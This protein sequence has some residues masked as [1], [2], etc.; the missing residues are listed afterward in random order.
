MRGAGSPLRRSSAHGFTLIEVLIGTAILGLTMAL[1]GS[2]LFAA[3]KS[4]RTGEARLGDMDSKRSVFA[5]LRRQLGEAFPLTELR[6]DVQHVLFDGGPERV[7]L[8]GHLPAHRGGG[9]LQII[10]LRTESTGAQ[11]GL[12]LY[13]R[14]AWP[15]VAF[16]TSIGRDWQKHTL[17]TDVSHVH[18]RY[19]GS[20]DD[21][22]KAE[23]TDFWSDDDRLPASIRLEIEHADG[24]RSIPISVTVR[25]RTASRQPQLYR[26]RAETS[27]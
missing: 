3:T 13:Y 27:R 18:F 6:G 11:D 5:F 21:R 25:S 8:I 12:V 2:A 14:D 15:D 24:Q 20:L 26:S 16:A 19:F 4:A 23:W 7:R 1:L 17:L 10:E 9:G 22:T